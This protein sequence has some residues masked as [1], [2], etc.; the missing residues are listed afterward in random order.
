MGLFLKAVVVD[1]NGEPLANTIGQLYDI[2]D[3]ANVAPLSPTTLNGTSFASNQ[4]VANDDGVVPDF[5]V[6]GKMQV[7]WVSGSHEIGMVA[8]DQIPVGGV[9]GQILTKSTTTDYDLE[10]ADPRGVAPGGVDGQVLLK[11]GSDPYMTRWGDAPAG[12]GG[13]GSTGGALTSGVVAFARQDT[14]GNWPLRPTSDTN[15]LVLWVG[16]D[17]WPTVVTTGVNGPHPGDIFIERRTV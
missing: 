6:A 17:D 3:T 7:K 8:A 10:W 13:G 16:V 2:N 1:D 15:V 11:D 4:V 5:L 14:Q 12:T 9:P